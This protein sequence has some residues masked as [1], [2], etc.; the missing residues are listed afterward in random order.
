[1][2]QATL[3]RSL[4]DKFFT[5]LYP[6]KP[7]KVT[8]RLHAGSILERRK[9]EEFATSQVMEGG[10]G[11]LDGLMA[12][13]REMVD[14]AG[15]IKDG[16]KERK[17]NRVSGEGFSKEDDDE[18]EM[19]IQAGLLSPVSKEVTGGGVLFYQQLSRQIS[20]F[21]VPHLKR[22]G[23]TITLTDAYCLYNRARGIDMVSPGDM[24][25]ACEMFASQGLGIRMETFGSG[26]VVICL[27]DAKA[28]ADAVRDLVEGD[29]GAGGGDGEGMTAAD[30]AK[31]LGLSVKMARDLLEREEAKGG[32]CRDE[33]LDGVRFFANR[34][35]MWASAQ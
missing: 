35:S 24:R 12:H 19:L 8:P 29:T 30:V 26:V 22:G 23:G 9:K 20:D 10:L 34:I 31:A 5:A 2:K 16:L 27:S 28:G 13:A 6:S 1:M 7:F 17:K 33:S 18:V 15:R 25:K 11:D 14:I 21:L 32:L 3:Q 4:S